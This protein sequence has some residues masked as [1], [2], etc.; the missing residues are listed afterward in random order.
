[1]PHRGNESEGERREREGR[2]ERER[3]AGQRRHE[4][5]LEMLDGSRPR[6]PQQ[7]A[8]PARG[9]AL[10][11]A[12][13]PREQPRLALEPVGVA[14][15]RAVGADDAVAG[16]QHGDV[17]GAVRRARRAHRRGPADRRRD[18]GV[19]AGLARPGSAA[20]RATPL[21]GRRCRGR[22]A[23]DRAA[24]RARSPRRRSAA[25]SSAI[26]APPWAIAALG[27]RRLSSASS[28]SNESRQMPLAVAATSIVPRSVSAVAQ[29]IVSPRPPSRQADGV[30]PSRLPASA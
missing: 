25:T 4:T 8:A 11:L 12:G 13:L 17:V 14:A 28:S 18:L 19:A 21:P 22:R 10:G 27:K 23:A 26:S 24:F 16:D 29:R 30:M 2:E 1:M 9:G 6:S 15:R 20:I 3:Q 7:P 5:A